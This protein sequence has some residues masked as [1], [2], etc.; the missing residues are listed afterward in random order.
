MADRHSAASTPE[1]I[2]KN[3]FHTNTNSN[4]RKPVKPSTEKESLFNFLEK[5]AQSEKPDKPEMQLRDLQT[6]QRSRKDSLTEGDIDEIMRQ[7]VL[8]NKHLLTEEQL[9]DVLAKLYLDARG[10]HKKQPTRKSSYESQERPMRANLPNLTRKEA[11]IPK[12]E[13]RQLEMLHDSNKSIATNSAGAPLTAV[14]KKQLQWEQERR[15]LAKISSYNPWGKPGCGAPTK[16]STDTG[17][18][19]MGYPQRESPR[20]QRDNH[21]VA[22]VRSDWPQ[23]DG[24][25]QQ[26]VR[27][28]W[29]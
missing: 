16:S 27:A 17:R 8:E 28:S 24:F 21:A 12:N 20:M 6:N 18:T 9:V 25:G 23:D 2:P 3:K 15:E 13:P 4:I 11:E 1:P 7:V 10:G 26:S 22:T 29:E 19:D 5:T 14:Q